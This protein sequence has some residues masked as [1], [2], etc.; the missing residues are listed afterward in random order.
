MD[1]A[2]DQNAGDDTVTARA[3]SP[4]PLRTVRPTLPHAS[5]AF[6]T[7]AALASGL[8]SLVLLGAVALGITSRPDPPESAG[9]MADKRTGKPAGA[10]TAAAS[11]A[12]R[13]GNPL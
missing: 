13:N 12:Q 11:S 1:K 8:I 6:Q 4:L 2:T 3:E 10:A 7:A 5:R 9:R